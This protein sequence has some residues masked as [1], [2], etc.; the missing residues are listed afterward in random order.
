[1]FCSVN[2]GVV[3][4]IDAAKIRQLIDIY[5]KTSLANGSVLLR[6]IIQNLFTFRNSG[7]HVIT[8]K[9]PATKQ[10]I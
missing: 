1:M 5:K 8:D 7:I 10:G 3:S 2:S 6:T 4:E 9:T